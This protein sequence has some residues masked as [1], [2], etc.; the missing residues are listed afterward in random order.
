MEMVTLSIKAWLFGVVVAY[1]GFGLLQGEFVNNLFTLVLVASVVA[2][3][4]FVLVVGTSPSILD[5][6]R[7]K[8]GMVVVI[9]IQIIVSLMFIVVV[10]LFQTHNFDFIMIGTY[11]PA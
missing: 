5:N 6:S 9:V 2:G 4:M 3:N 10:Q 11:P 8:A 7:S 1:L